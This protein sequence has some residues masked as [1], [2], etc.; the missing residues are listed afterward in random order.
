MAAT[1]RPPESLQ[2]VA[3][4]GRVP[5]GVDVA[6]RAGLARVGEEHL[7][8][9]VEAA[10]VAAVEGGTAAAVVGEGASGAAVPAAP[11]LAVGAVATR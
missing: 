10:G 8:V 9:V 1:S 2:L 5:V 11:P 3:G 7:V 6:G 4:L